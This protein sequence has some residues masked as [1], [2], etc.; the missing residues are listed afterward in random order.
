MKKYI[1]I[2][3]VFALCGHLSAQKF[4]YINTQELISKMP[5]VKEANSTLEVMKTMFTKR[6][7]EKVQELQAKYQ[8]LQRKQSTGEIAPIKLEQESAALKL[9]EEELMEFEQNNQQK[10]ISKSEELLKPVQD[11]VNAAIKAVA[12]ENGYQYIMDISGGSILY[13]D[14]TADVSSLLKAKL[15]MK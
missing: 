6:G 12:D 1:F 11:K 15:G 10:L 2:F 9:E 4:G 8:E 7:Q 3:F 14:P 5:E 13:A